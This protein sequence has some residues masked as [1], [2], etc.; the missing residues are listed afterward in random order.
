MC[1]KVLETMLSEMKEI[2]FLRE[3]VSFEVVLKNPHGFVNK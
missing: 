3:T 2:R 1:I